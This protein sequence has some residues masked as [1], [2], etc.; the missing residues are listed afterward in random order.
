MPVLLLRPAA[1]Q[2]AKSATVGPRAGCWPACLLRLVVVLEVCETCVLHN[3]GHH[4]YELSEIATSFC[5]DCEERN[6]GAASWLRARAPAGL[7]VVAGEGAGE[8][9]EVC[10]A[11]VY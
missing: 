2:T 8:A 7:V 6:A 5:S 4:I 1:S 9:V 10:E 11:R 3:T